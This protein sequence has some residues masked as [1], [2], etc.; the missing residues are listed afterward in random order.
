[1]TIGLVGQKAGMTRVFT[2]E[3]VSI[4]VTVIEIAPNK[5][6]QIKTVEKDG[7]S[8]LQ[9]S[10]GSKKP[11][12]V[13]K[14]VSGHYAKASLEAGESLNEFRVSPDAKYKL[15]DSV[16]VSIFEQGQKVNVRGTSL[17]KGFQGGVKRHNFSMQDASHGNSVSHRALGSTGQCQS[18]GRVFKGKK[19]PGQ[20]GAKQVTIQNLEVIKID[21]QSNLILVKGAVPGSR[22]GKVV[23]TAASKGK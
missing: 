8:S 16:D 14:A 7:Y 19:M 22:G 23:V 3:G 2:E 18:P 5:V 11:S 21:V 6:A 1:M 12:R 4:P 20:M 10:C 13:N 15:G 9:L 17:G